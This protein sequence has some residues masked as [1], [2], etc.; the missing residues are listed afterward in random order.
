ML[1]YV[2]KRIPSTGEPAASMSD[3]SGSQMPPQGF[4]PGLTIDQVNAL[5]REQERVEVQEL[6]PLLRTKAESLGVEHPDAAGWRLLG[7]ISSFLFRPEN[8]RAPFG[9]LAV[10]NDRRS[11][12]PDDLTPEQTDFVSR[13]CLGVEHPDLRARLGDVLWVCARNAK[14]A[15]DAAAAYLESAKFLEDPEN[16]PPC[17]ERLERGHRLAWMIGRRDD[18][19]AAVTTYLEEL[20]RKYA[21]RV[22]S[23]I[24]VTP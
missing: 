15:A 20:L 17:L 6:A 7:E 14:A 5:T 16:W 8:P 3:L 1:G 19:A 21:D 18:I 24:G 12:I 9:P 22:D 11:L 4:A 2:A 13:L 23:Y 10:F